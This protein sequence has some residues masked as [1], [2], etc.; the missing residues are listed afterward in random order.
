MAKRKS[1]EDYIE[2]SAVREV[3][4]I[5]EELD[6]Q[7]KA[8]GLSYFEWLEA[9][10]A[11]MHKSLAEVGFAIVT[12]DGRT[13]IDEIEPHSKRNANKAQTGKTKSFNLPSHSSPSETVKHKNYDDFIEDSSA[14]ELHLVREERTFS[15]KIESQPQ[16]KLVKYKTAAKPGKTNSRK[17]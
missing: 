2:D 15:D 16:K 1:Y 13:F 7:Q 17:K 4:R 6:R 11:D 12:R 14:P 8:S 3:H 10:E 5:R 9:T